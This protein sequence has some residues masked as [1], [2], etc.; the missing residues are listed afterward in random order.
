MA[1]TFIFVLLVMLIMTLR[2]PM[3]RPKVMPVREEFD[4][5]AAPLVKILG[6]VVII[7]T[8]ILYVI[9]W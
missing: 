3:A 9:F 5:T 4:M 7:I 8:L 2:K 6:G 1:I